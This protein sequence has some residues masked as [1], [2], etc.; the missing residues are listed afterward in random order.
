MDKVGVSGRIPLPPHQLEG[1]VTLSRASIL[2]IALGSGYST[3]VALAAD[4]SESFLS[5]PS[6]TRNILEWR[7]DR[8]PD[9]W[10]CRVAIPNHQ[11]SQI[12]VY[13]GYAADFKLSPPE[14]REH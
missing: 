14:L 4:D 10:V 7:Q 2:L 3:A 6:S 13:Y 11:T 9:F 5:C 12:V 8:G 1:I